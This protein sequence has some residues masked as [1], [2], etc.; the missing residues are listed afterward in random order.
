MPPIIRF[1]SKIDSSAHPGYLDEIRRDCEALA[2][3]M[4]AKVPEGPEL[5]AGLRKLLEAKDCFVRAAL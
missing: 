2:N 4:V 3:M 1:F 5:S